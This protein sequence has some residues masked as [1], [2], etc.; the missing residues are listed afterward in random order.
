MGYEGSLTADNQREGEGFQ[1]YSNGDLFQ[2]LFTSNRIVYGK[3]HFKNGAVY[4]GLIDGDTRIVEGI[5]RDAQWAYEGTFK[6]GLFHG[7][8]ALTCSFEKTF[9]YEGGFK[10]GQFNGFGTLQ[11]DEQVIEGTWT[12]GAL[13]SQESYPLI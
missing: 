2:G 1:L 8:G 13:N 6:N 5:Y 12:A 11:I 9:K 10:Q 7:E 3:F 4:E